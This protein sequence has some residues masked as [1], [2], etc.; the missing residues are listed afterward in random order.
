[1]KT[2]RSSSCKERNVCVLTGTRSEY[3]LLRSLIRNILQHPNLNLQL[4]VT[5]MHLHRE[6][7]NTIQNIRNDGFPVACKIRMYKTARDSREEL[8]ESLS[9]AVRSLGKWIMDN[10][11][12]FIVVLGDRLEALAGALAGLTANVAIVHLHGGEIAPGDMDDR[13]RYSISSLASVHCVSTRDARRRLI[14]TGEPAER[15]FVVGA[16]GMD[17]IY[18]FRK[19]VSPETKSEVRTQLGIPSSEPMLIVLIIPQVWGRGRNIAE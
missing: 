15:I 10:E 9:R 1:M 2:S 11:S 18:E 8:P 13:I 6:F 4:A 12:D 17:E 5:G 3:G 7:G 19:G 14:R 16:T